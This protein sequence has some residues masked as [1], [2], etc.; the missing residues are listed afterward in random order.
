[1][2]EIKDPKLDHQL[3][4]HF[5]RGPRTLTGWGIIPG[6]NTLTCNCGR[7][8]EDFEQTAGTGVV[9]AAWHK[10]LHDEGVPCRTCEL[11][12]LPLPDP[13]VLVKK[14][15]HALQSIKAQPGFE[16][17]E[18]SVDCWCEPLVTSNR[19]FTDLYE[20]YV[21]QHYG[22][23]PQEE[24]VTGPMKFDMIKH[25]RRQKAWS[26][27]TFGP[28]SRTEG[29]ID[30]IRKEIEEVA[31]NP[32]DLSEWVDL[33]ILA[34]DGATRRGFT[35][36]EIAAAWVEKQEVNEARTWPDWRTQPADK[37][38]EHIREGE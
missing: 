12:A 15:G 24:H 10:H 11:P 16:D 13:P 17:H 2:T 28:S 9:L 34:V 25:I 3:Q 8:N 6:W 23:S 21:I 31:A 26:A 30:H 37:A 38:I 27:S 35:E 1:M 19:T 5:K 4:L 29:V 22:S 33:I 32:D 36:T 20:S 7:L 18:D 14:I